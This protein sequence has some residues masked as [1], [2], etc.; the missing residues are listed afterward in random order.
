MHRRVARRR[1]ARA[2]SQIRRVIFLANDDSATGAILSGKLSVAAQA[3]I[4][5]RLHEQLAVDGT[6]RRMTC[7]ATLAQRFMLKDHALRLR[8]VTT[9]ALLVQSRHRQATGWLHDVLA[10]R[11]MALHT[12]HLP[13][14]NRVMLR[15][16][17]F[18]VDFEVASETR[19]RIA[20]GIHDEFSTAATDRDVPAAGAVA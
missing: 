20:S 13:F 9:G 18:R 6:V 17:E 15:K 8:T 2:A 7:R 10:V 11:V 19:L 16:I 14:A 3:K 12:A 5:V 4:W 1:P